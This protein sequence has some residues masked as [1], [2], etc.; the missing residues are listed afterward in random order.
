MK[1]EKHDIKPMI[2]ILGV[3]AATLLFFGWHGW[4]P[5][6]TQP[7]RTTNP[8]ESNESI[9]YLDALQQEHDIYKNVPISDESKAKIDKLFA[10]VRD[11]PE[12]KHLTESCVKFSGVMVNLKIPIQEIDDAWEYFKKLEETEK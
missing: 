9:D 5:P 1:I 3:C 7:N 10:T 12:F 2:L 4:L 8:I 6:P 11:N